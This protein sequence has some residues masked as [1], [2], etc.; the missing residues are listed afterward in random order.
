MSYTSINNIGI[1][2]P[3]A[4]RG[5]SFYKEEVS[6][7]EKRLFEVAANNNSFE[8][9]QG[10]EHFQNQFVIQQNNIHVLRH[11]FEQHESNIAAD[12]STHSGRVNQIYIQEEENL[13]NDYKYLEK[14][15]K[16]LRREFYLFLGK[17]I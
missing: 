5:L 11:K 8:A 1:Q 12:A 6:I 15:I 14:I 3:D 13:M 9:R 16:E 7:L 2:H 10:I 17:W 4:I